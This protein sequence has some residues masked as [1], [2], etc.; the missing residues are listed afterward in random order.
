[1]KT[2]LLAAA[3]VA[4]MLPGV[5]RAVCGCDSGA[6]DWQCCPMP[7]GQWCCPITDDAAVLAKDKEDAI[8]LRH[9]FLEMLT[10]TGPAR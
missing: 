9:V 4:I 2:L 6:S 5:A 8:E 10:A 7:G 3:V 1:M